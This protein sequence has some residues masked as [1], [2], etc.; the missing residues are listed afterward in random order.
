MSSSAA[1]VGFETNVF[2]TR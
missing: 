2:V 1:V